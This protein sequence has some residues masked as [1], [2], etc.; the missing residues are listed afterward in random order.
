MRTRFQTAL[1]AVL[2]AAVVAG[3]TGAFLTGAAGASHGAGT[4]AMNGGGL[5][6][7]DDCGFP[8]TATDATG[9][10]VT[11]DE[12]PQRVVTLAPSAA[13]TM[14]EIGA[15][16]KVV[17]VSQY[18]NYLDGAE[19]RVNVSGAGRTFVNAET[20]VGADPDLVLAPYV[21]PE[22]SVEK[23]RASGLTVYRFGSAQSVEA[24]AEKTRLTGR[25]VGE[26]DGAE[27]T[28]SEM[29]TDAQI[30]RN[31]VKDQPRP[32][33][34][35]VFFG[36]TAGEGT[37]IDEIIRTAG[38]ENV[39][40]NANITGFKRISPEVVVQQN[41]EWIIVNSDAPTVPKTDA[42]NSTT[43]VEQGNVVVLD[44]NYVSQPAPRIV[45][46]I[47]KLAKALHPDAYAQA[48]EEVESTPTPSATPTATETP[49]P[50]TS[51]AAQ[52]DDT[53][54]AIPGFGVVTAVAAFLATAGLLRRRR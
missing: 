12:E 45:Q 34:L 44:A 11:L 38:G 53:S 54:I 23:L 20:V 27:Q 35:Y 15:Q 37:F 1:A 21:I 3:T 19:E 2:V 10:Q 29:R 30:V 49:E 25:L 40:A 33:V 8:Y 17:G 22:A 13:Q 24:I 16:E 9:T 32:T 39:A 18:A 48:V 43:A 42:Y 51:A 50:T 5:A 14:W 46:P 26:C 47:T 52:T 28:V 7:T 41:P 36:Y 4:A 31:A 6:A